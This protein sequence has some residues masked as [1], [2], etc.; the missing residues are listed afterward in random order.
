MARS[1]GTVAGNIWHTAT[2]AEHVRP[3]LQVSGVTL[4]Q[5][6]QLALDAAPTM[7]QALQVLG[8]YEQAVRLAALLR[9]ES[10]CEAL[11]AGLAAAA[12]LAAPAP[13]SSAAEAKQVAALS[14]LIALGSCSEAGML[15][16]PSWLI[17]L[18]TLSQLESLQA[19]LLPGSGKDGLPPLPEGVAAVM[20]NSSLD[21]VAA[22]A[23]A[24]AASPPPAMPPPPQP[25]S[26]FGR[27]LQRMGFTSV[28]EPA[29][30][31]SSTTARTAAAAS[32][33]AGL[34]A[35]KDAARGRPRAVGRDGRRGAD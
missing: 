32:G 4:L 27:L 20:A 12:G 31:S 28:T 16:V 1:G 10:I 35:I 25:G 17:L 2:H 22:A 6:L 19:Q 15:G 30:G 18:R 8:G 9:L 23:A 34:L 3:M 33:R 26:G 13:H 24:A 21:A 5:C 29:G 7:H 11:V 14:K